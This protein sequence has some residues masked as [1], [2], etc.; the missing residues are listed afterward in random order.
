MAW[1]SRAW[2]LATSFLSFPDEEF[3]D[4]L[5][6]WIEFKGSPSRDVIEAIRYLVS[7]NDDVNVDGKRNLMD[8]YTCE[9]RRHF[10]Q[11]VAP[12]ADVPRVSCVPRLRRSHLVADRIRCAESKMGR[13]GGI[14]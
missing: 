6:E 4:Q 12:L 9:V 5:E 1:E 10:L 7:S 3:A 2:H 8:W 13:L 14:S 11:W